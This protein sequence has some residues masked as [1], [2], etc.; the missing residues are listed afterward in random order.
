MAQRVTAFVDNAGDILA[1]NAGAVIRLERDTLVTFPAPGVVSTTALVSGTDRYEIYDAS[2]T[3]TSWYR[4]RIQT[5]LGVALTD[6][7]T[8]FQV[9]ARTPI[10]TLGSVK[11]RLGSGATSTDD[12]VLQQ[13]VDSVNDQFVRHIG[14]YPGPS[15]DTSRTYHGRDAVR[16]G[17]RLWIPGGVRTVT[18]LTIGEST[19]A[20]ETAA[21]LTDISL[22]PTPRRAGEPYWYIDFHDQVTGSWSY[23]PFGYGNVTVTGLFGWA[24][25]PDELVDWASMQVVRRWKS[26]ATGD[27]DVV[28]N[29]EFGNA[30]IS[31]RLPAELRRAL[32]AY[33]IPTV[34]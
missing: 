33:R 12:D 10:A 3:S 21:T 31:Y 5:A 19:T 24:Q 26:R 32:D 13:F 25:V 4:F 14:Y 17:Y 16:N 15:T 23:Y 28:G 29:D 34:H 22:G 18:G 2:G 8:P 1:D 6:Y 30:I 9:I 11:L 27:P 20:T 7:S